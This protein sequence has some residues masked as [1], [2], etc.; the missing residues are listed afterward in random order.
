MAIE[1][2]LTSS[3]CARSG[4]ERCDLHFLV[5]NEIIQTKSRVDKMDEK[6]NSS[7]E[8]LNKSMNDLMVEMR[9]YTTSQRY[10]DD[11]QQEMKA[12]TSTNTSEINELKSSLKSVEGQNKVVIDA[13]DAM[14]KGIGE[15]STDIKSIDRT[16][17]SKED[18]TEIVKN[19]ITHEKSITSEKWID[20]LSAKIAAL[21]SVV[22]FVTFF[23][24]KVITMLLAM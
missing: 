10:R 21:L 22:S 8:A 20:S 3:L 5:E 12:T 11:H 15:L 16:V 24:L 23:T 9:D 14:R 17:L 13:I 1:T 7:V 4:G 19:I 6:F 2:E 18:V